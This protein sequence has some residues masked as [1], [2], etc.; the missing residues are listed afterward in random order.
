MLNGRYESSVRVIKKYLSDNF[1]ISDFWQNTWKWAPQVSRE[2]IVFV[3][4]HFLWSGQSA[5]VKVSE[6]PTL[7]GCILGNLQLDIYSLKERKQGIKRRSAA[8]HLEAHYRHGHTVST[9]ILSLSRNFMV[10]RLANESNK[11]RTRS[12]VGETCIQKHQQNTWFYFI[13][14]NFFNNPNWYNMGICIAKLQGHKQNLQVH[15]ERR[16]RLYWFIRQS[17]GRSLAFRNKKRHSSRF[18]SPRNRHINLNRKR[19]RLTCR[20]QS[21]SW[22]AVAQTWFISPS[23]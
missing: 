3:E 16:N 19:W 8:L 11:E 22:R 18:R 1:S 5:A 20:Y 13:L 9:A 15:H 2:K 12:G 4:T 21:F 23:V 10:Q 14:E 7:T 6:F 17:P